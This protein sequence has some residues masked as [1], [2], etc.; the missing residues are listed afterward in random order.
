MA[1]TD[2]KFNLLSHVCVDFKILSFSYGYFVPPVSRLPNLQLASLIT[3]CELARYIIYYAKKV[4][5]TSSFV[6]CYST[7]TRF[8]YLSHK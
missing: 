4:I 8:W 3:S 1:L 7:N 2:N 6:T 5:S